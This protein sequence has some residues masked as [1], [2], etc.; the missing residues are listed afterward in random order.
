MC[1]KFCDERFVLIPEKEA[2]VP[3]VESQRAKLQLDGLSQIEILQERKVP[4][5]QHRP[6]KGVRVFAEERQFV[7]VIDVQRV[8][9]VDAGETGLRADIVDV[10]ERAAC[11]SPNPDLQQIIDSVDPNLAELQS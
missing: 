5:A 8:D 11:P 6:D 10:L 4:A 7:N 3:D 9:A 1:P 2:M